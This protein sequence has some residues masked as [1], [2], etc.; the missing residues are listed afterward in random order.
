MPA[1]FCSKPS[2]SKC[3]PTCRRALRAVCEVWGLGFRE[4]DQFSLSS[5]LS[6][7]AVRLGRHKLEPQPNI[8]FFGT[9][10]F[11]NSSTP[12]GDIGPTRHGLNVGWPGSAAAIRAGSVTSRSLAGGNKDGDVS[13]TAWRAH[14]YACGVVLGRV[15]FP[16]SLLSRED[17][18][19]S[20]LHGCLGRGGPSYFRQRE[21]FDMPKRANLI[22]MM[23]CR[24]RICH[25]VVQNVNLS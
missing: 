19:I 14:A 17:G 1:C 8:E 25:V 24:V 4:E 6:G 11:G 22:N 21:R 20:K 18:R 7:G 13:R 16:L 2:L 5:N 9:L 15:R 3:S 23:L 10:L 12:P